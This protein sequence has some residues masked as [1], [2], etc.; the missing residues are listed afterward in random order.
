MTQVLSVMDRKVAHM[1][2]SWKFYK[3]N[4]RIWRDEQTN[5]E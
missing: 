3:K 1:E 5:F 4:R 2:I